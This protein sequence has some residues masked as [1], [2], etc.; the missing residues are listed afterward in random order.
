MKLFKFF[1]D[2]ISIVATAVFSSICYASF[3][4]FPSSDSIAILLIKHS[5]F[6]TLQSTK[7]DKK[8][9]VSKASGIPIMSAPSV[10]GYLLV[11]TGLILSICPAIER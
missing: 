4:L 9:Y 7:V 1:Y 2:K 6:F 8:M 3:G 5:M 11:L 10:R